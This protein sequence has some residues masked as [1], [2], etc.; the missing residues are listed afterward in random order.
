MNANDPKMEQAQALLLQAITLVGEDG[1]GTLMSKRGNANIQE[2]L[3]IMRSSSWWAACIK[4]AIQQPRTT[5]A[6]LIAK[7][8]DKAIATPLAR[9]PEEDE[10]F[11]LIIEHVTVEH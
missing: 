1:V 6:S 10:G 2:A 5:E 7:L 9:K 8:I 11:K 4:D 3:V